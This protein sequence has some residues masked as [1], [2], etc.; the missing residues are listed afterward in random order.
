M[1]PPPFEYRRPGT[2]D[3]TVELLAPTGRDTRVLAGGQSLV[4]ML[5]LRLVRPDLVVDVNRVDGL[6]RV[7]ID[8]EAVRI[9]ATARLSTLERHPPLR[10]AAGVLAEAVALVAHPQIRNRTTL[11]GSLCDANPAAELPTVAVALDA[12]LRLRSSRGARTVGADDFFTARHETSRTPDELLTA[13][14][15]PRYPGFRFCFDEISRRHGDLPF[16]GLCL[17]VAFEDGARG[18]GA[19]VAARIAAA[20][21]GERP[22]RLR[23][24]ERALIGRSLSDNLSDVLDA[25]SAEV[26]PRPDAQVTPAYR[27]GLLRTL[28][29]RSAARLTAER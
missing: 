24:T 13:V 27:R 17:G 19:V 20:G 21:V 11:G 18:R 29:R 7:E 1:K 6:D 23:A 28:I 5:N 15:F 8:D 4:R 22:L 12:R 14:E 26:A 10:S 9:G 16:V 3:E 25:A 2:V